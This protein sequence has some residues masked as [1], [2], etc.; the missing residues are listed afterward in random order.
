MANERKWHSL[1]RSIIPSV[2]EWALGLL[3]L[4]YTFLLLEIKK[5]KKI[6]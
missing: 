2:A 6:A 5:K 3:H 1:G 4:K